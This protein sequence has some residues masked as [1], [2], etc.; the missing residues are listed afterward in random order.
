MSFLSQTANSSATQTTGTGNAD[1]QF[2]QGWNYG[3]THADLGIN[4]PDQNYNSGF[5]QGKQAFLADKAKLVPKPVVKAVAKPV[6]T[7]VTNPNVSTSPT[8]DQSG[9]VSAPDD[10]AYLSQQQALAQQQQQLVNDAYQG[11]ES[12]LNQQEANLNEAQVTGEADLNASYGIKGEQLK[13]AQTSGQAKFDQY[14]NLLQTQKQDA[15]SSAKQLYEQLQSGYRQKFGGASSGGEAAQAI[16]GTEQQR[17]SGKIQRDYVSAAQDLFNQRM[18]FDSTY[19]T[20]LKSLD[21]EKTT[22]YNQLKMDWKD[23][24][25]SVM[26]DRTKNAQWKS[27]Q[28]VL[29]LKEYSAQ[30]SQVNQRASEYKQQIEMQKQKMESQFQYDIAM[31]QE[32]AKYDTPKVPTTPNRQIIYTDTGTYSVNPKDSNDIQNLTGIVGTKGTSTNEVPPIGTPEY[33]AYINK[34]YSN[35]GI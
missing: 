12:L 6:V 11:N 31:L 27:E 30:I 26:S 21:T 14:G 28:N 9:Q 20:N 15:L 22:A 19:Q 10:S 18:D 24:L 7:T 25:I 13:N 3:Y 5:N 34:L 33:D 17:Q 23:K 16:L 32:K 4:F 1:Q 2:N 35:V 29:A 8:G